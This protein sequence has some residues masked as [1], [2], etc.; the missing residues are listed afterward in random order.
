[1][2]ETTQDTQELSRQLAEAKLA[3]SRAWVLFERSGV[4]REP[5]GYTGNVFLD[6]LGSVL[7]EFASGEPPVAVVVRGAAVS[8]D[9][10]ARLERDRL[11]ELVRVAQHHIPREWPGWPLWSSDAVAVLGEWFACRG[12]HTYA[13]GTRTEIL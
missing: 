10:V 9:T 8:F 13:R 7:D 11:R 4:M 3:L 2:A 12:S 1:M 5:V 6:E